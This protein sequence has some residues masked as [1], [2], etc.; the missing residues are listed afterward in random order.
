MVTV[1]KLF[2]S[3]SLGEVSA[4]VVSPEQPSAILT[5]AH[6]AGAGMSHPFMSRLAEELATRGIATLRFNFP[7]IEKKS[8]RPDVSAVAHLTIAG[9]LEKAQVLFPTIPLFVGGKSFGGR[10]SS[11]LVALQPNATV[12]GIIFFGFPLHPAGKP[13]IDR[14]EHLKNISLPKLFLQ[15]TKDELA[16]W[17]LVISVVHQ[18]QSSTLVKLEG[19]DHAFKKGKENLL[20]VLSQEVANWIRQVVQSK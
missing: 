18:L 3:D 6:G 9:A 15:G 5:L 2:V 10:M 20:P 13:S 14:A 7:F 17:D 1:L 19:A 16:Q 12:R 4:E 8:R 11:Q